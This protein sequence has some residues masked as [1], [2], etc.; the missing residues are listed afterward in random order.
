MDELIAA[1]GVVAMTIDDD[2]AD[3]PGVGPT[4]GTV[5]T[6]E[7]LQPIDAN[8]GEPRSPDS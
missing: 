6:A 1:A 2:A 4:V 3:D 5:P 8:E 7:V